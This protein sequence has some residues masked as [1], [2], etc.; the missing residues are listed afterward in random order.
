[1]PCCCRHERKFHISIVPVSGGVPTFRKFARMRST[2]QLTALNLATFL[3][4]TETDLHTGRERVHISSK[5]D[6]WAMHGR[7]GV[8]RL[9]PFCRAAAGDQPVV[10][11]DLA[12][13]R[14]TRESRAT[15]KARNL[16]LPWQFD[17]RG[18][19]Q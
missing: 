4:I 13:M 16:L 9:L 18:Y 15:N 7:C 19:K 11:L 1:M 3:W 8:H 17:R 2:D 10:D 6:C 5:H 12:L 14:G